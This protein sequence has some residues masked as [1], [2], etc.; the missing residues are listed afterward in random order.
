MSLQ[1]LESLFETLKA[2][3]NLL[4]LPHNDPDP[5]AIAS[6]LA[7][8][9]LVTERL[10]MATTLAYKGIIGR[11]EN[12]ALVRYLGNPLRRVTSQELRQQPAIAL[13]DTQP[14]AGNNALP[15]HVIP[16]V[17]IDHHPR[18]EETDVAAYADVRTDLG[19]TSTLLTE[20]LQAAHLEPSRALATAL[21]YGI[22][23]DTMGL[24]RGA[25]PADA[26]AYFYLQPRIDAEALVDIERAQVPA[27][28]FKSLTATLQ[29]AVI[30][31]GVVSSYV[32]AL[33]YPDLAAEM[34]DLL[35]R[36]EGTQW[37]ICM[38]VYQDQLILAV[39][40]RSRRGGAGQLVRA[41]VGDRGTAGGHGV[42][43]GGQVPLGG[44]DPEELAYLLRQKALEHLKVAPDRVNKS[45]V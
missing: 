31:S 40:T 3:A 44:E 43:A 8:R 14:G 26:A 34:A 19:A 20:Y 33:R 11:A 10:G 5:D 13:V 39:R 21:F 12:K 1:S 32:G 17:V 7:L 35:M 16:R 42:M 30:Y 9:Y 15:R 25:S 27:A 2:D 23:T 24:G 6:V 18:R 28:Y 29:A 45:L 37:V 36:L 4:I 38:G 22:K 41:M